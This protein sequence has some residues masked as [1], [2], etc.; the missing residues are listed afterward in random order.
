MTMV[1]NSHCFY[2]VINLLCFCNEMGLHDLQIK[3]VSGKLA[4]CAVQFANWLANLQIDQIDRLDG[5]YTHTHTRAHIT[6]MF[7]LSSF[8]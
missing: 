8:S 2:S 5:T 7:R 3:Q 4:D 6:I 1:K